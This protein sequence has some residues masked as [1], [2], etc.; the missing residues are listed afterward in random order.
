MN[1][2]ISRELD[3]G[4]EICLRNKKVHW[5]WLLKKGNV[6]KSHKDTIFYLPD[7]NKSRRFCQGFGE[8]DTLLSA[9]NWYKLCGIVIWKWLWKIWNGYIYWSALVFL[10]MLFSFSRFS[11]VISVHTCKMTFV[12]SY[13]SQHCLKS[14]MEM[15]QGI[16]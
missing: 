14:T 2:W 16:N 13:C 3:R 7:W 10:T 8:I 15:F 1:G 6:R 11:P 4:K 5:T 12:Q 9:I